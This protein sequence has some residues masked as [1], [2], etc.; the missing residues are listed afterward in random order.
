M[1]AI[2]NKKTGPNAASTATA[3]AATAA[4]AA[5]TAEMHDAKRDATMK[6]WRVK[7]HSLVD[8]YNLNPSCVY[9]ANQTE[10]KKSYA[11]VKQMKDKTQMTLMVCTAACSA[12]CPLA[13][14]GKLKTTMFF[15]IT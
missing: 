9:N 7:F 2:N 11:G 13:I 12:K 5:A 1:S 3:A 8:K 10:L 15:I 4:A 6:K 14:V